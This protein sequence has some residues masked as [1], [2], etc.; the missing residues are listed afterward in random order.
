MDLIK[1]WD[2]DVTVK[3]VALLGAAVGFVAGLIQYRKAQRWKRTE[4]VAQQVKAVLSDPLVDSAL[5]MIDWGG[6]R[7]LLYPTRQTEAERVEYVSSEEV[8]EA[9]QYHEDRRDRP[10]SDKEAAIRDAF[11]HLFDGLETIDGYIAARLITADDV[12]P[13]LD[14]W[15]DN[16][17]KNSGNPRLRQVVRYIEAYNFVGIRHLLE[18]LVAH[19]QGAG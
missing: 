1:N 18:Q 19:S 14:Y 5:K 6:R 17:L 13:Y 2:A 4:W 10:F 3:A 12:R 8:I 11:D 7:I 15:A 9:L 16:L